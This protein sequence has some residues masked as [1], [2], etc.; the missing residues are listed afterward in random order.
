MSGP[1]RPCSGTCPPRTKARLSGHDPDWEPLPVQYADYA[2]WQREVLGNPMMQFPISPAPGL[3]A[4]RS[5]QCTGRIDT[6]PGAGT[7]AHPTR[8]GEDIELARR[9]RRDRLLSVLGSLVLLQLL[10]IIA[11]IALLR[12]A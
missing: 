4:R 7:P 3:L 8:A 12:G 9:R 6:H 11:H 1:S 5:C 2:I 10:L